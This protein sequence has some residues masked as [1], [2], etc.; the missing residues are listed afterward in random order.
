VIGPPPQPAPTKCRHASS[1]GAAGS[2][3]LALSYLMPDRFGR[4]EDHDGRIDY[5]TT[6]GQIA[7]SEWTVQIEIA[8]CVEHRRYEWKIDG[9]PVTAQSAGVPCSFFL[10]F[11]RQGTF[12]VEAKENLPDPNAVEDF[13]TLTVKVRDFLIVGLGDSLAAGEGVPDVPAQARND[14]GW[15][16]RRCDRSAISWQAQAAKMIE[17]HDQQTSVTF[18]HLACSG[19]SITHGLL[20]P[21]EGLRPGPELSPQVSAFKRLTGGRKVDALLLSIGI[22]EYGFGAIADFCGHPHVHNCQDTVFPL[23]AETVRWRNLSRPR[24][25][26]YGRA[27]TPS[28]RRSESRARSEC[29]PIG[30]T[31]PSTQTSS[32]LPRA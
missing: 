3:C 17:E 27:L 23:R 7:P 1:V 24:P 18:V 16:F 14:R 25:R 8:N 26:I 29:R 11:P 2:G 19:A 5:L 30:C 6:S 13:G 31:S 28:G 21:Y 4:D 15:E 20:G 12:T 10:K 9:R 32:P 22:N